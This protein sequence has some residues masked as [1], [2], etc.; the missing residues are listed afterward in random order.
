MSEKASILQRKDVVISFQRYAIDAFG[1]MAQGLFASLLIG[2]IFSTIGDLS[3][4]AAIGQIGTFAK[5]VPV[6]PWP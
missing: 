1:A 5:A 3:G 6:L 2:T 4:I